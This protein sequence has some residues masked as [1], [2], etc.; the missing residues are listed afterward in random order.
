[1]TRSEALNSRRHQRFEQVLTQESAAL[2][3]DGV[4]VGRGITRP[5]GQAHAEIVA[6]EDAAIWLMAPTCM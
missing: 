3:Q 1:M 6:M 2:V 5:P 4:V